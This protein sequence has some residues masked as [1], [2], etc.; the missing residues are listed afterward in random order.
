MGYRTGLPR[1]DFV[2]DKCRIGGSASACSVLEKLSE[3]LVPSGGGG[4]RF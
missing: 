3:S 2:D 1:W 4:R